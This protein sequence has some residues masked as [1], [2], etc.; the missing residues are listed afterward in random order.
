[1]VS[2]QPEIP[3]ISA[4][5]AARGPMKAIAP[6]PLANHF[7]NRPYESHNQP[8]RIIR[9][10]GADISLTR[11]ERPHVT[12][13]VTEREETRTMPQ[14]HR[15][16]QTA[17]LIALLA[18]LAGCGAAP[19]AP[20]GLPAAGLQDAAALSAKA[21]KR[22]A[23][24]RVEAPKADKSEKDVRTP[25]AP[26]SYQAED[27][28]RT[29]TDALYRYADLLQRWDRAYDDAE[30]DRIEQEML[31]TLTDAVRDI[32]SQTEM[33][34][35]YDA[36]TIY[37]TACDAADR[38]RDLLRR[39]DMAYGDYEKRQIVNQMLTLLT[40]ALKRVQTTS[41]Y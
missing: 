12:P 26:G 38:Y 9:C 20:Q 22:P 7:F 19:Q 14:Q 23:P 41:P 1:M 25:D 33:A 39:Y 11:R 18:T 30:R 34:Q 28:K 29:A 31:T 15:I 5:E 24:P 32:R 2:A 37:R 10:S 21:K 36:R 3:P 17:A 13:G 27:A 40:S 16:Q 6:G 35:E 4:P 8:L